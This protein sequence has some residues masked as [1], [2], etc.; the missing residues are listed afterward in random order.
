VT[1][2]IRLGTPAATSRGFGVAEFKK[3]GELIRETLD[4]LTKS[5]EA[6]N[7]EV[8]ASIRQRVGELTLRFPIY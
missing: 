4:G 7:G 2:G 1:S 5:G 8:E 6:G 3:V